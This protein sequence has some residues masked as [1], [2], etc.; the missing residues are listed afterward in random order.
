MMKAM[1]KMK[2][3]LAVDKMLLLGVMLDSSEVKIV[4]NCH[5]LGGER[6][7]RVQV[8]D[9]SLLVYKKH[10]LFGLVYYSIDGMKLTP[11]IKEKLL[12]KIRLCRADQQRDALSREIA[13][14]RACRTYVNY[15]NCN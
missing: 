3:K 13:R 6:C 14:I 5:S 9:I 2:E 10:G 4:D 11:K 15:R 1:E 12:Q 8:E 7:I